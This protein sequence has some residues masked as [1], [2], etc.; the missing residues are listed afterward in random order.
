M[1]NNKNC[2]ALRS[3]PVGCEVKSDPL[4]APLRKEDAHLIRT[5]RSFIPK[6]MRDML[7]D[8]GEKRKAETEGRCV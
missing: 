8:R 1:V 4:A 3:R 2:Q 5:D 6:G 7:H